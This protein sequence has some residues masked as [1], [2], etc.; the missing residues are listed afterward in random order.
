MFD[1][2][3]PYLFKTALILTCLT[4]PSAFTV[5]NISQPEP[6]AALLVF[7]ITSSLICNSAKSQAAKKILSRNP[8]LYKAGK[9]AIMTKIALNIIAALLLMASDIFTP[10]VNI[11]FAPE[12][13]ITTIGFLVIS[14]DVINLEAPPNSARTLN[15]PETFGLATIIIAGFTTYITLFFAAFALFFTTKNKK[16]SKTQPTSPTTHSTDS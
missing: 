16:T 12:Q 5:L 4:V 8:V 2:L 3:R 7:G 10:L 15:F 1:E 11:F 13:F 6:V 9:W 14:P